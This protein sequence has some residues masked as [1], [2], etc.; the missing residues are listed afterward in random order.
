MSRSLAFQSIHPTPSNH[1]QLT[2]S[3]STHA[4]FPIFKLEQEQED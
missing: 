4:F 2:A 1:A 3:L